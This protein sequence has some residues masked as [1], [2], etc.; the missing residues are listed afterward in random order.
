MSISLT[1]LFNN[2]ID[3]TSHVKLS[4]RFDHILSSVECGFFYSIYDVGAIVNKS[5]EQAS[6]YVIGPCILQVS[7]SLICQILDN[8]DLCASILQK[9]QNFIGN[10]VPSHSC[11]I[12]SIP[13]YLDD[14][15]CDW[16]TNVPD[17]TNEV[18][19]GI[20]INYKSYWNLSLNIYYWLKQLSPKRLI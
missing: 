5:L 19:L 18:H 6:D 9:S 7:Q 8:W 16:R 12:S 17:C 14:A 10:I 13:A 15:P 4:H 20:I 11:F 3:D 2:F 1:E